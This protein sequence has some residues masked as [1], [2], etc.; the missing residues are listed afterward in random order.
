MSNAVILGMSDILLFTFCVLVV[1]YMDLYTGNEL[2][3]FDFSSNGMENLFPYSFTCRDQR[4]G[5]TGFIQYS[6]PRCI[7]PANWYLQKIYII[8]WMIL[9]LS[10]IALAIEISSKG[11]AI[12]SKSYQIW[13]LGSI[14]SSE[15]CFFALSFTKRKGE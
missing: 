15:T 2:R 3:S 1:Y 12:F 6:F 14:K 10:T 9:L 11:I 4:H 5:T 7:L 8:V 13:L